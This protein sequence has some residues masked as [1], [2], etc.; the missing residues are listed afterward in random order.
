MLQ[1]TN[2]YL[3]VWEA[4]YVMENNFSRAIE[5]L[6]RLNQESIL[7]EGMII[8]FIL[9][10]KWTENVV[11]NIIFIVF[12]KL[13]HA[14]WY[15]QISSVPYRVTY[16]VKSQEILIKKCYFYIFVH[17][18]HFYYLSDA[19]INVQGIFLEIGWENFQI[20]SLRH[21][22]GTKK[23]IFVSGCLSDLIFTMKDSLSFSRTQNKKTVCTSESD[24]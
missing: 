18:S 20:K 1:L 12:V 14:Y 23:G 11:K 8:F 16:N 24:E 7:F 9:L 15:I 2:T 10:T 4:N 22:K 21:S 6:R 5:F 13:V 17:P 3:V 19:N